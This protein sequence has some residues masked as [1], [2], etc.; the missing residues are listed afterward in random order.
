MPGNNPV[1]NGE[2]YG[3]SA[4]ILDL[5]KQSQEHTAQENNSSGK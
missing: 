1:T 2:I 3:G 4:L 5:S